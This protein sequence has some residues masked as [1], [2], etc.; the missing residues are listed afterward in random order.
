MKLFLQ[1]CYI[2]CLQY[3]G[4]ICRGSQLGYCIYFFSCRIQESLHYIVAVFLLLVNHFYM[5]S[6][7]IISD[8]QISSL[9]L[10]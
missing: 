5:V 3:V 10:Y 6:L 2:R 9:N 7:D 8:Q 1:Y 4:S